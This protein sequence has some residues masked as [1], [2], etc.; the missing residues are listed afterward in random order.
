[1]PRLL[2]TAIALLAAFVPAAAVEKEQWGFVTSGSEVLLVYGVP[3]SEAVTLSII[4]E[5]KRKRWTVVATVLPARTGVGRPAAIRLTNGS[6]TLEFSGKTARDSGDSAVHV[7][8]AGAIDPR[9]FDLLAT[10]TSLRIDVLSAREIVTLAGIKKPLARMRQA[11][12]M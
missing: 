10:G 8:A 1:M 7:A 2:A 5:P 11:C 3:E 9:L 12:R 4:C 6:S